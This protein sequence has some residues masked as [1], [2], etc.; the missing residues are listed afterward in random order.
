LP[1]ST[2]ADLRD[3]ICRTSHL[4]SVGAVVQWTLTDQC[5]RRRPR[6][7]GVHLEALADGSWNRRL[8]PTYGHEYIDALPKH[9]ERTSEAV[10]ASDA[11]LVWTELSKLRI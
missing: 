3:S 11:V 5:K 8:T 9:L 6:L 7:F 2:I 10:L 1:T 4:D